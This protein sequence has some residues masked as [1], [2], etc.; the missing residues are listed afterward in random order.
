ML[1]HE[2]MHHAAQQ[3]R[4]L[5]AVYV[6]QAPVRLWHWVTVLAMTVLMATGYFIGKPFLMLPGND[7]GMYLMGYVRFAHFAAGYVLAVAFAG[8][9]YWAFVGNEHA[10]QIFL[11]P[12][13]NGAWWSEVMFELRWYFFLEDRPKKYVGHNPLA[14][15]MMF[16]L[17]V[18]GSLFMIATGFALYSEGAGHGHWS[19][20]LF[21]WVLVALGDSQTVHSLHRLG[22]WVLLS[23]IFVHVY[24]AL[25]EDIMSRQSIIST[26]ISGWRSFRD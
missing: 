8:R 22:L 17:F 20:L 23:F 11:P 24:A 13:F 1:S 9:I 21:G 7:P 26:M 10:R 5:H 16:F 6:Y 12:L 15:V 2:Q 19:D 3:G 14:A 18:L 25:R 4:T